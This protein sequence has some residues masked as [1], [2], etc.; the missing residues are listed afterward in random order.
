M[1][2]VRALKNH[3][4]A[5]A[6]AK[7]SIS[8]ERHDWIIFI[9]ECDVMVSLHRK[10][11]LWK[12]DG[13]RRFSKTN[14][15]NTFP[16]QLPTI[17]ITINATTSFRCGC[18]PE[19]THCCFVRK[20]DTVNMLRSYLY[21]DWE[22]MLL[23]FWYYTHTYMLKSPLNKFAVILKNI[24]SAFCMVEYTIVFT[25]TCY[26]FFFFSKFYCSSLDKFTEQIWR[27]FTLR[28]STQS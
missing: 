14:T 19:V 27:I 15:P 21:V 9:Y 6:G 4:C 26:I 13:I 24:C 12:R 25:W 3:F 5:F 22:W 18:W 10:S 28:Y 20:M 16:K 1:F 11:K 23:R 8:S 7:H 2:I 17:T